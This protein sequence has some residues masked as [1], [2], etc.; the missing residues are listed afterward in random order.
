MNLDKSEVGNIIA[1]ILL[2]GLRKIRIVST[3]AE[4]RTGY[5]QYQSLGLYL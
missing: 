2:Y 3:F 4:A 1:F 5:L